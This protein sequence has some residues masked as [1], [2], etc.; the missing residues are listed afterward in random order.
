MKVFG[1]VR[2]KSA[3]KFI[4]ADL[5]DAFRRLEWDYAWLDM[6]M[7][8]RDIAESPLERRREAVDSL[9]LRVCNFNPDIIISYGLEA[10]YPLFTDIV[11]GEE[12][13]FFSFF[14]N[15]PILCFVFD[16][17]SPFT[18]H[19]PIESI[20]FIHQMQ[21]Q[22][23]LFLCWDRDAMDVM[24][25]KGIA[26]C[27]YFPMGVN[28]KTYK[29]IQMPEAERKKYECDFCFVG[30][31]TS[32]RIRMLDAIHNRNLKIYGYNEEKWC[33]HFRLKTAYQYPV[34][35]RD[36]LVKIYNA[37]LS[38]INITREHGESSLNMRVYEAMACGSLL[39]TD[40]KKDAHELFNPDREILIYRGEQDFREKVEWITKN[41]A[42]A[43]EIACRGRERILSEHTYFRRIQALIP[44][45]GRFIEEFRT[46][47]QISERI[48]NRLLSD[49][50]KCIDS[51]I[52]RDPDPLNAGLFHYLKAEI[53]MAK[54]QIWSA[55]R[56]LDQSLKA[57]PFLICAQKAKKQFEARR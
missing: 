46:V 35:D 15:T 14:G 26:N 20:P 43:H 22:Q 21:S 36:E 47:K 33:S 29:V 24:R 9:L 42:W 5:M 49:A 18:D 45:I 30:G 50:L 56:F 8:K 2:Q 25:S 10:F 11:E 34:F 1:F 3:A 7:W 4:M 37:S 19:S 39:L 52:S 17:G 23:F 54:G 32:R 51:L 44:V 38:S 31:P 40:D 55:M 6:E 12:A 57:N 41:R 27:A 28:E 13:P 53:L 48:D 16:F